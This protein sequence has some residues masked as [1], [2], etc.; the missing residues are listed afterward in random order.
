MVLQQLEPVR[1]GRAKHVK[2]V[3]LCPA[4]LPLEMEQSVT[5]PSSL[6]RLTQT[7]VMI[8]IPAL[9]VSVHAVRGSLLEVHE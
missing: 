5:F 9:P 7:Y 2:V 6:Y 8:F 4:Y 1:L 3:L